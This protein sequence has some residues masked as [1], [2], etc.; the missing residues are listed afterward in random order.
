MGGL[1]TASL[2]AQHELEGKAKPSQM[3]SDVTS[4]EQRAPARKASCIEEYFSLEI[5]MQNLES[6]TVY[7]Q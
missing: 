1:L 6:S 4:H 7:R 2:K 3:F 5:T